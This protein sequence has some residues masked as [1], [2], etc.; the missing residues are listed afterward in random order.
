MSE[1]LLAPLTFDDGRIDQFIARHVCALC[2]GHLLK[3]PGPG[4]A[5]IAKCPAHG[6][7]MRH[8]YIQ[9]RQAAKTEQQILSTLRELRKAETHT[10]QE[11][12]DGL[13]QEAK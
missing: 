1:N 5:W 4:R 12:L 10:E 2:R 9:R 8:N 11:L 3:Y 6:D 7:I 13:T